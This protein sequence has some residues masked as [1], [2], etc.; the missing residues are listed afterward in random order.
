[1]L[2]SLLLVFILQFIWGIC[3]RHSNCTN[4]QIRCGYFLENIPKF[5]LQVN[6]NAFRL[7]FSNNIWNTVLHFYVFLNIFIFV[8][9]YWNSWLLHECFCLFVSRVSRS[10]GHGRENHYP[11]PHPIPP[12]IEKWSPLP[13]NDSLKKTPKIKSLCKKIT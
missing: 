9:S 1:M 7:S 2:F 5:L 13:G 8:I 10:V 11:T 6:I 12:A 4:K 3:Y